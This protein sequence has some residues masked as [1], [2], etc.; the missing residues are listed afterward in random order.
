M[1]RVA[2]PQPLR[3]STDA[4]SRNATSV[5]TRFATGFAVTLA[6][7]LAASSALGVGEG[8][9]SAVVLPLAVAGALVLVCLSLIHFTAYVA[10]MLVVRSSVDLG[11]L[12][13][14]SGGPVGRIL[15]P[16]SILAIVFIIAAV[17]W[18]AAQRD[19]DGRFPGSSL[20]T[21]LL[22]FVAAAAL[23]IVGARDAVASAV[24]TVRILAAVMMFVVVEQLARDPRRM[25]VILAAVYGSLALPLF[26]VLV[27]FLTGGPR[28][29]QKGEFVR[30][31]GPFAQS[32]VFGRYLMLLVV[33]GV[34]V[35]PHV[36]GRLRRVL[37]GLLVGSTVCL[38][39][40]YTR[41]ALIGA[42][43]GLVVVGV[44]HNRRVLGGLAVTAAVAALLIPGIAG[45]FTE[46]GGESK[47]AASPG[48]TL[49]WRLW[50]WTEVL[51]LARKNPVTGIGVAQTQL[52][53]EKEVQ[54]H[55]DFLRA[56]VET[57]LVGLSA[58]IATLVLLVRTGRR[59]IKRSAERTLER[60]VSVGF[61]GCVVAFIAASAVSN[62]FSN[63]VSLWYFFAF[64]GAASA[65]AHAPRARPAPVDPVEVS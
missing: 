24:E 51:P 25:R 21:A 22:V 32:N 27:G 13:D 39:L 47:N 59:A 10:V 23:S 17:A 37:A 11:R 52:L 55:N 12:S 29:E 4:S 57:G 34:A 38:L 60:G 56:Y 28:T 1:P 9:K 2:A 62:V 63:V 14:A 48:N 45:R 7:G 42:M 6:A 5:L 26:I 46:L 31:I 16:S 35:Y 33:M 20:R 15:N 58:Y 19:R 44:H 49:E 36:E 18:L 3:M 50:Y 61:L 40:T 64:A 53:T 8:S 30:I 43:L 54:P 65:I 41:S